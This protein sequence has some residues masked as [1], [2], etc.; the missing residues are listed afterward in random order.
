MNF[1]HSWTEFSNKIPHQNLHGPQQTSNSFE[2]Q[3]HALNGYE[4]PDR[5]QLEQQL[6]LDLHTKKVEDVKYQL[7]VLIH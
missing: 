1:L 2:Q 3:C 6:E 7:L 4:D 5:L